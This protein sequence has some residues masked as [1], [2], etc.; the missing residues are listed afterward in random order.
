[1]FKNSCEGALEAIM[2]TLHKSIRLLILDFIFKCRKFALYAAERQIWD[3]AIICTIVQPVKVQFRL[4]RCLTFQSTLFEWISQK[5]FMTHFR[6]FD[7]I[8]WRPRQS[9]RSFRPRIGTWRWCWSWRWWIGRWIGGQPRHSGNQSH[10]SR[11]SWGA[12]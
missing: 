4:A 3:R 9:L 7:P 1:M 8:Q 6:K 11:N 5:K 2:N 12:G 10:H